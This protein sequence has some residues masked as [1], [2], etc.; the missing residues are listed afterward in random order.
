MHRTEGKR[1]KQST[2]ALSGQRTQSSIRTIQ[3][4]TRLPTPNASN[5]IDDDSTDKADRHAGQNRNLRALQLVGI[6]ISLDHSG[7]EQN[8]RRSADHRGPT[9]KPHPS[10]SHGQPTSSSFSAPQISS[11]ASESDGPE[12]LN[13]ASVNGRRAAAAAAVAAC[14]PGVET[15]RGIQQRERSEHE[16]RG[17]EGG[18]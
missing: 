18:A 5:A 13:A 3:C 14:A 11:S 16:A 10:R 15:R 4:Q 17:S 1:F 8:Q 7:V 2:G 9:P 12:R 6:G